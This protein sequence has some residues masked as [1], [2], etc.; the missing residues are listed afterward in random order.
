[1]SILF[2][3]LDEFQKYK[4]K[5]DSSEQPHSKIG[6]DIFFHL[7]NIFNFKKHIGLKN[8][9]KEKRMK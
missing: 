2:E 5:H 9:N 6:A 3:N 1:M 8:I 4:D 7:K